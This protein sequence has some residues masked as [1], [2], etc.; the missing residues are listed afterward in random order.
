M[1]AQSYLFI[2]TFAYNPLAFETISF[3]DILQPKFSIGHI[4]LDKFRIKTGKKQ[5]RRLDLDSWEHGSKERSSLMGCS[6]EHHPTPHLKNSSQDIRAFL[7]WI[8]H[9]TPVVLSPACLE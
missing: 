4:Y 9:H 5:T 3:N 2:S 1:P 8:V 6:L 7:L